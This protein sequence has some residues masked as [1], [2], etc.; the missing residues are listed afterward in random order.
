MLR[1][2]ICSRLNRPTARWTSDQGALTVVFGFALRMRGSNWV[3]ST[4]SSVAI[5]SPGFRS[6]PR[7]RAMAT[8]TPSSSTGGP[9]VELPPSG[10]R[11]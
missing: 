3:Y 6:A 8:R 10:V 4:P 1:A 7:P 2:P 5:T 11:K 9:P